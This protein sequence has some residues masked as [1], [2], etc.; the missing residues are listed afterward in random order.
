MNTFG[1]IS[2]VFEHDMMFAHVYHMKCLILVT[3]AFDEC[4]F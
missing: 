4:E 2:I 3:F 1:H